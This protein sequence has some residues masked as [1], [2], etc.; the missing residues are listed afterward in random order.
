MAGNDLPDEKNMDQLTPHRRSRS[1]TAREF[2]ALSFDERLVMVH[3]AQGRDKY[4]LLLDAADGCQLLQLLPP[5]DLFL[6]IKELGQDH[7]P[8]LLA[9]ASP[10]QAA[11]CIDLDCWQGDQ[12]DGEK[13]LNWLL[14]AL[15]EGEE[16]LVQRAGEIDFDL[17][18]LVLQR[19]MRV[20]RGP[21]SLFDE[22]QERPAGVMPYELEYADA[23]RAKPL[24][25]LVDCLF[26]KNE[27]FF[28]RLMEAL[29]SEF[30]SALEEQVYQQRRNRLL[31]YGFPDPFEALGVYAR[32]DVED[33]DLAAYA[34]PASLPEPGPVAPGFVLVAVRSSHLLAEILEAG[35]GS[36]T[37]WDLSFLLNRVMVADGVDVGDSAAVQETMEQVYGYLNIALEKTCGHSLDRAREVFESTYLLG[38]LRLGYNVTLQLQQEARRLRASSIGPFLDGPYAALVTALQGRKPLYSKA[39]DGIAQAGELPFT[40]LQQVE[41]IRQRLHDVE[42]QRRLFEEHFSFELPTLQDLE[43]NQEQGGDVEPLTLSDYFLTALANRLLGRDFLPAPIA[44]RELPDLHRLIAENGSLSND[45]RRETLA[46]LESLEPGSEVFGNFCLE[47]WEEE[48]CSL[49]IDALDPRYIGGL[50]IDK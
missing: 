41:T 35:I 10:E 40:A 26:R 6:L 7:V 48:F 33:F 30:P 17:L 13:A 20:V 19:S 21:E 24:G 31:E 15:G 1:I 46:W 50:L 32:V 38:L 49:K 29:R 2:N 36:G 39:L 23:E 22:D 25:I 47:V 8:E 18:V 45:L 37:V 9:M 27:P 5:Q 44:R 42:V 43:L 14:S 11:V 16:E 34:R 3:G 12:I 4:N 28:L